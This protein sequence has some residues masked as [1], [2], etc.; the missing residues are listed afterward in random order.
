MKKVIERAIAAA[1]AAVLLALCCAAGMAEEA[2]PVEAQVAEVEFSL[3][4][5]QAGDGGAGE[6]AVAAP[7]PDAG[8]LDAA[9]A[10]EPSPM[11]ADVPMDLAVANKQVVTMNPGRAAAIHHRA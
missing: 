11:A 8:S 1:L 6:R 7:L 5:D 9:M 4:T 3:G 2:D 10:V